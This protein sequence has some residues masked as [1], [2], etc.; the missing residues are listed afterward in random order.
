MW[1]LILLGVA[2]V[3]VIAAVEYLLLPHFVTHQPESHT[4]GSGQP[5]VQF[6]LGAF[7]VWVVVMTVLGYAFFNGYAA[8]S[9]EG[10]DA[11]AY[12]AVLVAGVFYEIVTRALPG[13]P[14]LTGL[15]RLGTAIGMLLGTGLWFLLHR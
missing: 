8:L 5:D 15:P 1:P 4:D 7:P 14:R 10:N 9:P 6:R 2:F 13:K 11:P 12:T 3:A